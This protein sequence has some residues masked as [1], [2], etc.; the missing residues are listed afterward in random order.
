MNCAIMQPTYLPWSGYFNL[1]ASVDKFV[2][3]DNVQ[4]QKNSWHN[5][6]RILLGKNPHWITV[7][8]RHKSINQLLMETTLCEEKQWRKKH[9]LTMLQ[10]YS[11]HPYFKVVD[12]I[13][14]LLQETVDENLASLNIRIISFIAKNLGIDTKIYLSSETKSSGKRAERVINILRDVGA[15]EYLSPVGAEGY[16]KEDG[17]SEQKEILLKF[18]NFTPKPYLQKGLETFMPYLS[19]LDILA[20]LG[21]DVASEYIQES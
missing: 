14:A 1:M 6:N 4:F 21:W 17:F 10:N 15:T 5:R 11:R 9:A 20:N 16:L 19:I 12:E 3:L 18:Q 7:P 13:A 2:F 8:V